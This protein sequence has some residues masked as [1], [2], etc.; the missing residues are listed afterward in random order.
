MWTCPE[1]GRTFTR[2]RQ[3][4]ACGTGERSTVLR[5]RSAHLVELYDQVEAFV[6][7]LGPVECVTRERYILFRS[8][9]VF[10]DA[11]VMTDALRLAIHLG[12]P[13]KHSAF[14]KVA[15]DGKQVTVVVKL[16]QLNEFEAMK[17][18]L[19]EAYEHSLLERPSN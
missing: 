8:R 15:T 14:I 5:G 6:K 7:S 9:R 17:P 4:H 16:R 1:C 19:R 12:R 11:V 18:F 3:R 2:A 10:A 13:V